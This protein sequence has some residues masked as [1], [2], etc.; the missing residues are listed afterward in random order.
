MKIAQIAPLYESV[1]PKLYGGTERIVHYLTEELVGLG[2]KVT[3]FASGDS[4]TSARLIA[5]VATGLRLNPNCVDSFAHHIVQM[6]EVIERSGD[7]DILHFHTDYFHFPYTER[8]NIPCLTTLHGR[9]D[10]PDLQPLYNKFPA[11]KVISISQNQRKPLPQ[12][13]WVGT[14]LHGIPADLHKEGTGDGNYVAFLGRVSPEKGLDKA[15]EIALACNCKLKVA[16]K[17]DK[18]DVEYY[19]AVIKPI[20]GHPLIEFIGEINEQQKTDFIGKAK[21][22]LFPIN[23]EEPFGIV[24]VEAMACGTPVIA[25]NAGS[26]KEVINEGVSGYIVDS[27]E[28]AVQALNAISGLSRKLVRREFLS[29]FTANRMA[30]DYLKLYTSVIDEFRREKADIPNLKEING[31]TQEYWHNF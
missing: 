30:N 6:E 16:A 8:L 20:L 23:W 17:I 26:V 21:A 25:F 19:E 28:E 11:Q 12:A 5:N 9:L 10:I 29:K 27:V 31:L 18:A 24:M 4:I 7:F 2:H 14:V 22:L 3:L 13:N 1:P 15:I